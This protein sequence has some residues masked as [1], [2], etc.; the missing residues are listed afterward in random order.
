M[1]THS[2]NPE[3]GRPPDTPT[4]NRRHA[5]RKLSITS[6][7]KNQNISP[8]RG[9]TFP[10]KTFVDSKNNDNF[11][12]NELVEDNARYFQDANRNVH[13]T[14]SLKVPNN[15]LRNTLPKLLCLKKPPDRNSLKTLNVM[16]LE[17]LNLNK[18][19]CKS[20]SKTFPDNQVG[21]LT[22]TRGNIDHDARNF[23]G[24]VDK[25][26]TDHSVV[27]KD[28]A[29]TDSNDNGSSSRSSQEDDYTN[30]GTDK[31]KNRNSFHQNVEEAL[32][33]LLWQPYEYQNNNKGFD[34]ESL[35]SGSCT[36]TSSC[37]TGDLDDPID[38]TKKPSS[39]PLTGCTYGHDNITQDLHSNVINLNGDQSVYAF[40][41]RDSL[42]NYSLAT[43]T[44]SVSRSL[45]PKACASLKLS[46]S[47]E[48]A[49]DVNK[50]D[51]SSASDIMNSVN[52]NTQNNVQSTI[53]SGQVTENG[54]SLYQN[55][56]DSSLNSANIVGLPSNHTRYASVPSSTFQNA[57]R[58]QSAIFPQHVRNVSEPANHFA[59][60]QHNTYVAQGNVVPTQHRHGSTQVEHNNQQVVNHFR[61][62][63]VPKSMPLVSKADATGVSTNG[64]ALRI[65]RPTVN[66]STGH[67]SNA[68]ASN[69][70]LSKPP[71]SVQSNISNVNVNFY[72]AVPVNVVSTVPTIHCLN[73]LSN[74]QGNSVSNVQV[75]PLGSNFQSPNHHS[76]VTSAASGTNVGGSSH[77]TVR[78]TNSIHIPSGGFHISRNSAFTQ[79]QNVNLGTEL[80]T[81]TSNGCCPA[82]SVNSSNNGVVVQNL[83][84]VSSVESQSYQSGRL[85]T[86]TAQINN[87]A[88][89]MDS[90]PVVSNVLQQYATVPISVGQQSFTNAGTQHVAGNQ[91]YVSGTTSQ[92]SG[93]ANITRMRTF[94]STEAQTDEIVPVPQQ[95][96]NDQNQSHREQRRRERRER[97]QNRRSNPPN[98]P[99][100][101]ENT[102]AGSTVQHNERLP[103]LL[104]SH[105]PPPYSA[106]SNSNN[107]NLVPPPSMIQPQ[108][109]PPPIVP[110]P[111]LPPH[112]GPVLQTIVPNAVP[113]SA[114]VFPAPQQVVPGQVPLV[115][116]AQPV[117]VAVPAPASGF[118]FPFPANG[119]R[120]TR[121]SEDSPKGCCG[122]LSW[123]PGSL[124]WFIALIALVA[125]C[126]VLV[127][128]A[129]GAMRPAGR[130]HLTVSLLM[131]GVGIVLIT[132]SGVAWRLTSHDSSTCRSMLGLGSTESVDVCTRR[133]VPRLPPSYGRPHHPYAAMMYPEFQYRPPPPSYQASMQEYRLR[134]LLLDRGNTP[135]IQAGIQNAVSPPPTYRSHAG[136]LLRAPLSSRRDA[137][138]SEYSCP[139]SY[140]SQNSSNRPGTL[141]G[142][143]LHSREHSLSVSDS[144]HGESVVNV[145]NILG[146]AEED[147][148][149][150]N[151]TLDSLKMEPETDLNPLKML[152]KGSQ[153]DLEGSKDGNLVTIVQTS[154][155][156]PV[157]VTVSGCSQDNNS[158]VQITEIPSEMEILA[159]L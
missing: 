139:P 135:Q 56:V 40:V 103:D 158:S 118:R 156:N 71:I 108:I 5:H 58:S 159:H 136:S 6:S 18:N 137:T 41:P 102:Q 123:K 23:D 8:Y 130:D 17:T 28:V 131:I 120:R 9:T 115:Q 144:N 121:F 51:K 113:A 141:Q 94:T 26:G 114:F 53:P 13:E 37:S 31:V 99:T 20:A 149:L 88:V 100:R 4:T 152:L 77:V 50:A 10:Q 86:T 97:R 109:V 122:I 73:T 24:I 21:D 110:G 84:S 19:C 81:P 1:A 145:V 79:Q 78:N 75:L 83:R 36:P 12:F 151:I 105:L 49:C 38:T 55:N 132:V 91:Y 35:Y 44:Q 30:F 119:F 76:A 29:I 128:T 72:R 111:I 63:S 150:D 42:S 74:D 66:N 104:D 32:N 52:V 15:K 62:S 96:N 89:S 34:E 80:S 107:G 85:I 148:A 3:E 157:I 43:F 67:A 7:V 22:M 155:Q 54:I 126:C 64:T 39:L 143:I 47:S 82:I 68:I 101:D 138:Q 16:S 69:P 33:S 140:R 14:V 92:Q 45:T 70:R 57:S 154:D 65:N 46:V 116:G 134:L 146:S 25:K 127:G 124:R 98:R 2:Q 153:S 125:V 129:L 11:F 87:N 48:C 93:G 95:Q 60:Y 117:P 90:H 106:V 112:H 59:R 61:S 133:F 27:D 147:I 142:S